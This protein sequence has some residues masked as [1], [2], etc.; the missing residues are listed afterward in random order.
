MSVP[1]HPS[2]T[3]IRSRIPTGTA[4]PGA[5][6]SAPRTRELEPLDNGIDADELVTVNCEDDATT[7]NN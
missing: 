7:M 3:P 6:Q 2:V 4:E 5:D 1:C